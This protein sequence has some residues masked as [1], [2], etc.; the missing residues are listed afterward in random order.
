MSGGLDSSLITA[1]VSKYYK[2]TVETYSIGMPGSEDLKYSQ[3]VADHLGTKHTQ[4]IMT[5]Q[6]FFDAI[7][8]VIESIES[9]DTTSV[10]ASVGNYLV[11]KYIA[12]HSEAKVILMEMVQINYW[13]I[14]VFS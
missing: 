4:I 10:R 12:E 13:W 2:G 5:E 9:Y 11:S 1:L 8:E 3:I 7:P 6:E 14:Y